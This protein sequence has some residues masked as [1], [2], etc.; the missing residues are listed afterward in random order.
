MTTRTKSTPATVIYLRHSKPWWRRIMFRTEA[1]LILAI[2]VVLVI[3]TIV[4]PHFAQAYT[5]STLLLNTAPLLLL[6]LPGT[7]IIMTGEI[8]LSVGSVLG[9]ASVSFGLIYQ[10]GVP[11][12]VAAGIAVLI[13]GVIGAF[14]GVMV[15]LVGLPSLAV[16]IGTLALFRGLAIG[17]LGTKAITTFPPGVTSFLNANLPGVPAPVVTVAIVVLALAFGVLLHFTTFGRGVYAIGLSN[18]TAV[19]SGVSVNRTKLVLFILSGLVAGATGVYFTL[20]YSNAIGSNGTGLE[21][22]VVT[23]I[24]LG[25]VSIW[26]GR[27][28][29]VGAVVGALLIGVL[30]KSLQVGGIGSDAISV[31]T[32]VVLI[33]SVVVA[34]VT[35]FAAQ[36]RRGK[37]SAPLKGG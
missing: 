17:L 34:S 31:V 36:R 24:V 10:A 6:I 21:L 37:A 27:G 14:N 1:A 19:F 25:G 3:A 15:T 23:A 30:T 2:V 29:L 20:Q 5:Y 12:W 8:D 4:I 11:L 35:G 28:T 16:T 22:Q 9:I 7:L 18:E 32:G 26:G 33:L 13:G